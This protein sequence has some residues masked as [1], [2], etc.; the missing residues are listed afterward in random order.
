[1][2]LE[3]LLTPPTL[4]IK[5]TPMVGLDQP[6]ELKDPNILKQ[7]EPTG[8]DIEGYDLYA[9]KVNDQII[10]ALKHNDQ[11]L[12]VLIG[13]EITD[14]PGPKKVSTIMVNRSWTPPTSRGKGYSPALY[15]G[16]GRLGYRILSDRQASKNALRVWSKLSTKHKL[17]AFDWNTKQYT[18]KDP[19]DDPNISIVLEHEICINMAG[20][21]KDSLVWTNGEQ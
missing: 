11:I 21:L 6:L 4:I 20:I 12:T 7:L 10:F 9:K 5:E 13:R 1:M 16:L 18:N 2:L 19:T 17:K 15:D 3:E 14:F 8:Q